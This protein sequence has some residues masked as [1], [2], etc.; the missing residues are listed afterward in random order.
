MI[1]TLAFTLIAALIVYLAGRRDSARDPRLTIGLLI[2]SGAFPLLVAML[3]KCEVLPATAPAALETKDASWGVWL[4]GIWSVGFL[5][6]LLRLGIASI[7]L[8]S[9]KRR[10]AALERIEGIPILRCGRIDSPVAAGIWN[11]VILVPPTWHE[12]SESCRHSVVQH[13]LEHHQRHDPLW[14][15]L[16]ALTCAVHWYHPL[17]HWMSKRY[18]MQ[19]EFACDTAVLRAGIEPKSYARTLCDVATRL[20]LAPTAVAMAQHHSLDKRVR[21]LLRPPSGNSRLI[22]LLSLALLATLTASALAILGRKPV[23]INTVPREEVELR[24][25]ANPFPGEP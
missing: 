23:V 20:T 12:W 24:L 6:Q 11:P 16:A 3:P 5:W 25:S 14:R 1:T 13:E 19:S 9:W 17:V 2:V 18:I 21:R 10:S 15:L 7:K 8:E 22:P 4:I